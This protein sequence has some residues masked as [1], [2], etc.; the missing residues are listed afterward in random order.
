MKWNLIKKVDVWC[1]SPRIINLCIYSYV[2]I[3]HTKNTIQVNKKTS[4][5]TRYFRGRRGRCRRRGI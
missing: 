5:I 3:T 1:F 4:T 2:D